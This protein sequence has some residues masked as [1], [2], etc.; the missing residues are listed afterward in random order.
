M[1]AL[2]PVFLDETDCAVEA[3][4][5][6]E[7]VVHELTPTIVQSHD[8]H[9]ESSKRKKSMHAFAAL[10]KLIPTSYSP[11]ASS[12]KL[13]SASIARVCVCVQTA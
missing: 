8:Q 3:L 1:D 10:M 12:S 13:G 9:R 2:T 7:L 6:R 11:F 4:I 5:P